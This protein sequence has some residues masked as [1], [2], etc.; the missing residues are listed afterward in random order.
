MVLHQQRLCPEQR[1]FLG[2]C[3]PLVYSISYFSFPLWA[4]KVYVL[5]ATYITSVVALTAIT[6][7]L[8]VK[9]RNRVQEKVLPI[10]TQSVE[11]L[12]FFPIFR[13]HQELLFICQIC[14]DCF[15]IP[16]NALQ[17]HLNCIF[18]STTTTTKIT[19]LFITHTFLIL[20]KY[21]HLTL[22]T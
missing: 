19:T 21:I 16:R 10:L 13:R 15:L 11:F 1:C 18:T 5:V 12:C 9:D 4:N 6:A 14:L 17:K 20:Q 3:N 8:I 7:R 22:D 2:I